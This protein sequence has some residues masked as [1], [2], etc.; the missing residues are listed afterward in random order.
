MENIEKVYVEASTLCNLNCTMCMR[1]GWKDEPMG[2]MDMAVYRKLMEEVAGMDSVHTIFFGGIGEPTY[3]PEFTE[4]IRLAKATGKRVECVTNGTL[5][6]PDKAKEWIEAGLDQAWFSVDGFDQTTYGEIRELGSFAHISQNILALAE[7]R[8]QPGYT[9]FHIGLTFVAMKDNIHQL[10]DLMSFAWRCSA[11]DVKISHVLPYNEENMEQALYWKT[12]K[13]GNFAVGTVVD[14]K[15]VSEIQDEEV[16]Q[17]NVDFPFMDMTEQTIYPLARMLNT[18]NAFSIMG[19]PL[20]RKTGYCPFVQDN[21]VFVKWNGEVSPCMALLHPSETYLHNIH[22]TIKPKS[23]GNI[24][25]QGLWDIWSGE[26]YAS[27]RDRVRR[28]D[29][30]YCI[31]CGGCH[32][33][34]SNQ[35]DCFKNEHPTCGAC[36]WAQGFIQ[37]P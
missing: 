15:I 10:F 31:V 37:C 7:L 21:N 36:L 18:V 16:P 22:R 17:M 1:R 14:G 23:Y 27:F 24:R 20:Y 35:E 30:S 32:R 12:L 5:I 28:F 34:E 19:D 26:E 13:S 29:F 33:I 8:K 4:M 6:T 3:H 11:K 25:E 9:H 2:H